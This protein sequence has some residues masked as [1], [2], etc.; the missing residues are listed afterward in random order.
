MS[1]SSYTEQRQHPRYRPDRLHC[2]LGEIVDISRGGARVLCRQEFEGSMP[3]TLY[4]AQQGDLLIQGRIQWRRSLGNRETIMG[5]AFEEVDATTRP[6]LDQLVEDVSQG[7][8]QMIE[9]HSSSTTS[10]GVRAGWVLM[11]L[12]LLTAVIGGLL[13]TQPA[14]GPRYLPGQAAFFEMIPPLS[15]WA[16]FLVGGL[17]LVTGLAELIGSGESAADSRKADMFSSARPPV[18]VDRPVDESSSGASRLMNPE[19]LL[20]GI[21]DS[22]LGGV[23]VL[24]AIRLEGDRQVIDFEVQLINRAAENLLGKSEVMVTGHKISEVFPCL[25]THTI[26]GDLC[27]TV[28][29]GLP[30]QKQ[31]RLDNGRWVQLAVVQLSDG[32]VVTFADTSEQNHAQA[33]LRHVADHDELTGLPN[34]KLL[35]EH[36][37]KAM[38]R[39]RRF[40]DRKL[41]VLFLDFDRFKI[42]NDTLGHEVGDLLLNSISGRLRENIRSVDTAAGG[43]FGGEQISARLGGDEFV[44]MLDGLENEEAAITVANRLLKTFSEPH[45]LDGHRVVS[46][47]SIGIVISSDAYETVD[48]LLR[49]ADTA[50]YQAK[51]SGK[52]RYVVFDRQMHEALVEQAEL[53]SDLREAVKNEDFTLVYEPIVEVDT[54]KI[55]GFETLIRWTHKTRGKVSPENFVPM[56]EELNLIIPVGAWVIKHSCKQ[57]A[58]WKE[59]G[60]ENLF[61]NINLSRAQ[62]YDSDL[63]NLL[64]HEIM[65]HSLDPSCIRLEI[66]ETMVMDD[67]KEMKSKLVQLKEL[68]IQLALDDF[69]TGHSS[70]NVLQE[71]PLDILKI[72]RS[73]IAN[74]GDAVRRYGA[75]IATITEL[76]H[77]LDMEVIAE[78]IEQHKQLDLLKGLR[79]QYAQGWLYSRAVDADAAAVMIREDPVLGLTPME[80]DPDAEPQS[81]AA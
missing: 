39:A 31:Y 6:A 30:V 72:D 28:M 49:D 68:G 8:S 23:S 54:G 32:L 51:N 70:L 26:L 34:R 67:V 75:I 36:L 43:G 41:A 78:G 63:V 46:T 48:E 19:H 52:A 17:L 4:T 1:D 59:M 64:A 29:T 79:C 25:M 80:A 27:S 37:D 24:K 13:L 53:E 74:A 77:N 40:P 73:F 35:M 62:L 47:A 65:H 81:E 61:L 15:A 18:T 12:G 9:G 71:L 57:L 16:C 45:T 69:G 56:A 7:L 21:L 55:A 44:V 76:A 22:S 5:V 14:W 20:N 10:L 11:S 66:T 2:D 38:S 33:R 50:M 42:V 60:A 3:M 58:R